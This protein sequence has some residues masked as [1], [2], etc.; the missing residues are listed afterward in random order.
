MIWCRC[1]SKSMIVR[2]LCKPLQLLITYW[3]SGVTYSE[4][5]VAN[6]KKLNEVE[7]IKEKLK[8]EKLK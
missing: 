1:E 5:F 3:L 8:Q 6:W 4:L 7:T 2:Q